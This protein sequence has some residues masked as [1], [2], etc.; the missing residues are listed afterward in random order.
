MSNFRKASYNTPHLNKNPETGYERWEVCVKN[1]FDINQYMAYARA[2]FIQENKKFIVVK[3]KG[4]AV[5]NALKVV[6]LLKEN[7]GDLH[8]QIRFFLM[9]AASRRSHAI[10][11]S[12]SQ[13]Q[14]RSNSSQNYAAS[15]TQ[16]DFFSPG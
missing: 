2:Q 14:E 1:G 15:T 10:V 6:Q 12:V 3:A 16:S 11:P 7:L 8:S 13:H 5:E 9:T 4:L